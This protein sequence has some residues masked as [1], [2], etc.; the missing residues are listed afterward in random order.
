MSDFC[1][2]AKRELTEEE[3]GQVAVIVNIL[4]G[5]TKMSIEEGVTEQQKIVYARVLA[6]IHSAL[7]VE[8]DVEIEKNG[9]EQLS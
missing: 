3:L 8:Y 7:S 1:L 9:N 6:Y 4:L 5:I 2:K